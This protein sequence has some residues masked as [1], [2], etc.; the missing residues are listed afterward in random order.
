MIELRDVA[1]GAG[2]FRLQGVSLAI[3]SGQYAVLM[4]QTGQ[5]KT[6][7]LEVICGLRPI[8]SGVVLVQGRDV[9]R[10]TPGDRQLG[11]VPQDLALF[12]N[13]NVRAHLEFAL[14]LRHY[15]RTG[16][17]RR[18]SELAEWLGI[19]HLLSRSIQGLSGGEAQR[20]ALGRAIAF[21]Q[22]G[23]ASCRERV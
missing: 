11:Y 6:T 12:A 13:L 8:R 14:H 23:R 9:T 1:C 20:V 16:I 3:A 5:G 4:G 2:A 7:L 17:A 19:E 21:K 18:T 10:L 22:I 15:S